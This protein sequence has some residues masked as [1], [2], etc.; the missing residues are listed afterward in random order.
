LE[1]RYVFAAAGPAA[2]RKFGE[3]RPE[4]CCANFDRAYHIRESPVLPRAL[5]TQ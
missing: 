1:F 4:Q 2:Q 3:L 5:F